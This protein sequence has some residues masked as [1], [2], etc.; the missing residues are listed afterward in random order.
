MDC[1]KL[2]IYGLVALIGLYFL[3]ETCGLKL[4]FVD[5]QEGF[6]DGLLDNSNGANMNVSSNNVAPNNNVAVANNNV[7]LANNVTGPTN[8][9]RA[10]EELGDETFLRVNNI[11]R[12][13]TYEEC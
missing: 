11:N 1:Q 2:L 13:P 9:V 7:A 5:T 6:L 10:S 4:P 3:R 8:G 12:T